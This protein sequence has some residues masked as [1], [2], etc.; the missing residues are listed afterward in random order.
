MRK[1]VHLTASQS[2]CQGGMLLLTKDF[3]KYPWFR[4]GPLVTKTTV[5]MHVWLNTIGLLAHLHYE[6]RCAQRHVQMWALC[7]VARGHQHVPSF[8]RVVFKWLYAETRAWQG[9]CLRLR[10][11]FV[12][13]QR[14]FYTAITK[15]LLKHQLQHQEIHWNRCRYLSN[16]A[17]NVTVFLWFVLD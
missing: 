13:V 15:A 9:N 14:C 8:H 7:C 3:G 5:C 2:I 11:V 12:T 16:L 4:L 10:I 17:V 1:D 6:T